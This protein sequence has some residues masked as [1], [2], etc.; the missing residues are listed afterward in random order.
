PPAAADTYT[1][2]FDG[3]STVGSLQLG[4]PSGKQTLQL[5]GNSTQFFLNT[6][7]INSNGILLVGDGNVSNGYTWLGAASNTSVLTNNGR[8][9]TVQGGGGIRYL[10]VNVTNAPGGTVDLAA[11]D[12]RQDCSGA[13]PVNNATYVHHA[14]GTRSSSDF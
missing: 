9:E 13:S 4:A 3:V 8:L 5:A 7:T 11:H 1:V 14:G 2:L 6:G 12:T 10:R